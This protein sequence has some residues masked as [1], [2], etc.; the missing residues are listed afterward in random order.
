MCETCG[1]SDLSKPKL[2]NLQSG[3]TLVIG[4][5]NDRDIDHAVLRASW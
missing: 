1:C 4:T 3:Q 2:I 5:A